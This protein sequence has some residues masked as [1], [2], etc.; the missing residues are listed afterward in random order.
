MNIEVFLLQIFI[1]K[2]FIKKG[3]FNENKKNFQKSFISSKVL[4]SYFTNAIIKKSQNKEF[5]ITPKN[6]EKIVDIEL[7]KR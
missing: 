4:T 6:F 2:Y 3:L 1:N 5:R 7:T